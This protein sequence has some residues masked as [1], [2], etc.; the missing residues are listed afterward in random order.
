M[1][2]HLHG[3]IPDRDL[4]ALSAYWEAFPQLRSQLFKPNRSGYSDLTID[5]VEVQKTILDSPEFQKFAADARALISD[6][7]STHRARLAQIDADTQ[8][9]DLVAAISDDLLARFK[10]V[11][12]LDEYDVYEQLMTYWHDVMHDDVFLIMNDGWLQ[13]ARPRPAD[14]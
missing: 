2:A 3:G 11:P 5:V 12:L 7:Y 4:D 6:W 8:P 13:A 14:H 9:N 1:H 10:P